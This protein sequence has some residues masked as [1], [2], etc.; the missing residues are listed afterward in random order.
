MVRNLINSFVPTAQWLAF[1]VVS[2]MLAWGI[3]IYGLRDF[4]IRTSI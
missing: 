2:P 4:K 1:L 3:F